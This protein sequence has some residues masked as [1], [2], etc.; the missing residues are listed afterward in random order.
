MKS[1]AR[2]SVL[3]VAAVLLQPALGQFSS[4]EEVT[5]APCPTVLE[6]AKTRYASKL[7][8]MSSFVTPQLN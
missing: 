5:N 7:L 4:V 6:T 2:C 3:A 1:A 8:L